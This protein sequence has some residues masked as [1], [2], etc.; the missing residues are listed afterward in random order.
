MRPVR[1]LHYQFGVV[2][3]LIL[4]A[5]AFGLAAPEGAV[6][7]VI[8]VALQAATLVAAVVASRAHRWVIRL[9]VVA[10]FAGVVGA[11][12]VLLGT[13]E[14]ADSSGRIL[15]L[16]YISLTPPAIV[17]GLIKQFREAGGVTMQTMFAVLCLYLLIGLLFGVTYATIQEVSNDAF[18]TTGMGEGDDF[19]YFS[20]VTLTTVGFGDLIAA[21]DLGRSLAI[22]EALVGQIYLVTVV[23][24][25]VGNLRAARPRSGRRQAEAE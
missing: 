4:S 1:P 12:L 19:L 23:A 6:G 2:L 20:F 8:A 11:T 15:A 16:L 18:F 25:I 5:L 14:F 17:T 3:G 7:H 13:D 24:V 10:A 22:T 9:S 21:T